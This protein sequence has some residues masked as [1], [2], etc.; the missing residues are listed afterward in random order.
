MNRCAL[1]AVILCLSTL[2]GASVA[3]A[4]DSKRKAAKKDFDAHGEVRCAQER[5]ETLALCKASVARGTDGNATVIVTFSNGFARR[6]YFEAR[7]FISANA[8]MSG[9]GRD[10]DWALEDGRHL[11]RVDDQRYVVPDALVFGDQL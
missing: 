5:G 2:I 1:A 4:N 11:I 3:S 8:T 7:A 6:L 9:A 10:T